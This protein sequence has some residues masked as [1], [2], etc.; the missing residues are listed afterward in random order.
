MQSEEASS[1]LNP[2]PHPPNK[3]DGIKQNESE[4]KKY[5]FFSHFLLGYDLGFNLVKTP[6][7]LGN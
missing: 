3:C 6:Q 7:R 5:D 2:P 4:V 1:T